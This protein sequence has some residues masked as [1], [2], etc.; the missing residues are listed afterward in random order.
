MTTNLIVPLEMLLD[1]SLIFTDYFLLFSRERAPISSKLNAIDLYLVVCIFLVFGAL[2]EY[3]AILLL[4]KK[5]RKPK[6][7]IDVGL[8][9]MFNNGDATQ[10]L[11]GGRRAGSGGP[12]TP[13]SAGAMEEAKRMVSHFM[14]TLI[15]L[16]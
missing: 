7:S 1:N 13:T 2:M 3:A 8:K 14:I 16:V 5:R 4:L 10:P 11:Q 15:P 12:G 6:Y 9:K